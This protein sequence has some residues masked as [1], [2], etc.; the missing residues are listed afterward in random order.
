MKLA[1]GESKGAF[2]ARLEAEGRWRSF[3]EQREALKARGANPHEA[4]QQ[5]AKDF[6]EP[7]NIVDRVL[8]VGTRHTAKTRDLPE[9][10]RPHGIA[11]DLVTDIH[12]FDLQT[13][14]GRRFVGIAIGED[15]TADAAENLMKKVSTVAP[16]GWLRY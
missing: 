11:V 9:R 8:V 14:S 2:R 15:G 10:C 5:A 6:L 3:L 4:W 13:V 12:R 1:S 7:L 16:C